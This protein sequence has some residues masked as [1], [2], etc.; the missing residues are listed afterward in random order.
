M[1]R[2]TLVALVVWVISLVAALSTGRDLLFNTLYLITIVLA[3][4]FAW[5]WLNINRVGLSRYTRARRSQVGRLAEEQFEVVNRSRLP[6]L[7]LEIRDHSTLPGHHPSRVVASLGGRKTHA[8]YVR[9]PCYRRGRYLLGPLT[10]R[11]GDP[12]GIFELSRTLPQTNTILV[13]P[14]TVDVHGFRLPEGQ[15]PGGEA[16]RTRTHYLT[17]NVSTVR[18]YA[19]GDSFNR[20]HWRSTARKGQLIVK[21]FELDPTSDVWILLDLEAV[22]HAALP[23]QAP[24]EQDR[25]AVLW[26]ERLSVLS[27]GLSVLSERSTR[28]DLIPATIEYAVTAAAS[29]AR[30]YLMERRAVG[31]IAYPGHRE[32]IQP[33]RGERQLNKILETLAVLQPTGSLAF[34]RFLAAESSFLGRTSTV[35]AIT[36]STDRA[37]VTGMREIGR[38][39]ARGTAILVAADSFGGASRH[40]RTLAELW[41]N[42]IPSYLLRHGLAIGDALSQYARPGE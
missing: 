32:I 17:T 19:P 34:D 7:W 25:P 2:N 18:D 8:W 10:V 42:N 38:R 40:E 5:S 15:M 22:W 33:D 41:A 27:D 9:T 23:W 21:E 3:A 24:D 6:K 26:S 11:S 16:A 28:F 29:L 30:R 1:R 37:W 20:I 12:L 4:S 39:G 14:A 36:P 35:I 31:L 13:Y